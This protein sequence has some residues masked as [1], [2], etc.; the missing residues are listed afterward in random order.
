M[1]KSTNIFLIL[2]PDVLPGS[3]C[4]NINIWSHSCLYCLWKNAEFKSHIRIYSEK[5]SAFHF[6]PSAKQFCLGVLP[7]EQRFKSLNICNRS[8]RKLIRTQITRL[9]TQWFWFARSGRCL[10]TCTLE[11]HPSC[12]DGGTTEIQFEENWPDPLFIL[13]EKIPFAK[14]HWLF[15]SGPFEYILKTNKSC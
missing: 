10:G 2:L 8:P 13:I 6:C 9:Y 14:S 1:T 7:G 5:K 4:E 15:C 3:G 11:N 12:F